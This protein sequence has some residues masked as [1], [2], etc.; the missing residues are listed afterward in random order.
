MLPARRFVRV[1]NIPMFRLANERA[2]KAASDAVWNISV[3]HSAK[4]P[5]D[6]GRE[7]RDSE[8]SAVSWD[9]VMFQMRGTGAFGAAAVQRS[10]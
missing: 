2:W 3:F 1:W 6:K 7:R 8:P 5:S 9:M 10:R 4:E